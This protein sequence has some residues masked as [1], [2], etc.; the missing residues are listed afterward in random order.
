V[1][2]GPG[3]GYPRGG[4]CRLPVVADAEPVPTAIPVARFAHAAEA[5]YFS[6]E[7]WYRQQVEAG[8]EVEESF[9][10]VTGHW[11]VRYVLSTGPDDADQARQFVRDVIAEDDEDDEDQP[12]LSGVDRVLSDED[13]PGSRVRWVPI[14][15]TLAAGSIAYAVVRGGAMPGQADD[16]ARAAR[17]AD[18][19]LWRS[20]AREPGPWIQP[21][22]NPQARRELWFNRDGRRAV[23]REDADGDGEFED[24]RQLSHP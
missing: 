10:A 21:L 18:E 6:H 24:I 19:D 14:V 2:A 7:L 11:N 20:M 13:R 15:L 8:V 4:Y 1:A 17:K 3:F 22:S 9:D 23:L 12:A 5:G 16:R